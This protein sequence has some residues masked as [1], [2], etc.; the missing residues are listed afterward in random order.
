MPATLS[1]VQVLQHSSPSMLAI[2]VLVLALAWALLWRHFV[3][4]S[5]TMAR[6]F[7]QAY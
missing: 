3:Q 4:Q 5:G 6:A 7:Q 2:Y 1:G